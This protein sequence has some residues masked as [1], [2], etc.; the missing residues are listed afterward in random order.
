MS[1]GTCVA[2]AF[3]VIVTVGVAGAFDPA[4]AGEAD[5]GFVLERL[6]KG[7]LASGTPSRRS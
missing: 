5:T 3:C 2:R 7:H 6:S 4:R 1:I